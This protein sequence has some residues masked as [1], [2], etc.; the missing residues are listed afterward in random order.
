MT[1]RHRRVVRV[2]PGTTSDRRDTVGREVPPVDKPRFSRPLNGLRGLDERSTGSEDRL[3]GLG[4]AGGRMTSPGLERSMRLSGSVSRLPET[5]PEVLAGQGGEPRV[6]IRDPF[7]LLH[8][9]EHHRGTFEILLLL[10]RERSASPSQLRRRLKS[11]QEA[12]DAALDGL[13]R[14][15]L[16]NI[17]P[18]RGFPFTK[19]YRLTERGRALIETPM[20]SW[21][22]VLSE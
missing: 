13:N 12:L 7:P 1:A 19:T 2:E 11:G 6:S 21:F 17:D 3:E 15:G 18:V 10:Y 9:L 20:G 16:I 8:E 5:K 14:L 22:R 4:L